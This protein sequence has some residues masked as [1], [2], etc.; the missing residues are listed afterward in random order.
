MADEQE[1]VRFRCS[2]CTRSLKVKAGMAG[3]K[4]Y[5]PACFQELTVPTESEAPRTS[6][7]PS[8]LYGVDAAPRDVR[9]MSDRFEYAGVN[10]PLCGTKIAVLPKD[11]G[12]Q[13]ECPDCGTMVSVTE[14]ILKE[15]K[16]T[17]SE[18]NRSDAPID[19]NAKRE[20]DPSQIYGVSL[21]DTPSDLVDALGHKIDPNDNRPK[22]R[23]VVHE[24][25]FAVYCPLCATMQYVRV[26]QVGETII[27]P[28]CERPFPIY[29]PVELEPKAHSTGAINFE[30]GTSYGL[31][32]EIPPGGASLNASSSEAARF[33]DPSAD[34]NL[35]PVVCKLCGTLMHAPKSMIGQKKKCPDCETET[36][37]A[38]PKQEKTVNDERIEPVFTG[39]YGV[40][41]PPKPEE[42]FRHESKYLL[43]QVKT[44]IEQRLERERLKKLGVKFVEEESDA[45]TRRLRE[46]AERAKQ[47]APQRAQPEPFVPEPSPNRPLADAVARKAKRP[48]SVPPIPP[49]VPSAVPPQNTPQKSSQNTLQNAPQKTPSAP[50]PRVPNRPLTREEKTLERLSALERSVQGGFGSTGPVPG[51]PSELPQIRSFKRRKGK[52]KRKSAG[53]DPRNN[54]FNGLVAKLDRDGNVILTIPHPPSVTMGTGLFAPLKEG[55]F[56]SQWGIPLVFGILALGVYYF[57][58]AP[59]WNLAQGGG[60]GVSHGAAMILVSAICLFAL[61]TAFWF[62]SVALDFFSTF[63]ALTGGGKKVEEWMEEDLVGGLLL[64]G[65]LALIAALAL[66]PTLAAMQFF[67]ENS[68]YIMLATLGAFTFF[69]PIVFLST[70]QSDLPVLP[71]TRN[72]FSSFFHCFGSWFFFYCWSALLIFL[73]LYGISLLE[74]G[75][76]P[77][78]LLLVAV[79]LLPPIIA[80]L[81]GRLGWVIEDAARGR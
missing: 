68:P 58:I 71:L 75:W 76:I 51:A 74:R 34:P 1:F 39:G 35:I 37:I 20:I 32:G 5:C 55:L 29:K 67:C 40:E 47:S 49:R 62:R 79:T 9:Q 16:K 23:S 14:E 60:F 22:F 72:V 13:V 63:F 43:G 30:G 41:E 33:Y 6:A 10:C 45:E 65:R 80:V 78:T 36:L 11:V 31:A 8:R 3:R 64:G 25:R 81:L 21:S 48:A 17:L 59:F 18:L 28:D 53:R 44:P 15:R 24:N 52:S 77:F 27:C 7:D 57:L 38:E 54:D 42:R 66:G 26:D 61:L 56:W 19:P 73:P 12:T 2:R 50:L 4:L 70:M 69:F 46:L